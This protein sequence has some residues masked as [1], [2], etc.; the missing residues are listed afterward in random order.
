MKIKVMLETETENGTVLWKP[1]EI[2]AVSGASYTEATEKL[3]ELFGRLAAVDWAHDSSADSGCG[4]GC[5]ACRE[6]QA[7]R[8][9]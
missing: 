8:D 4:G 9:R 2:G 7:C 6:R 1:L 5:K 3:A